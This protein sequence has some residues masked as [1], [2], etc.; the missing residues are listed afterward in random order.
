MELGYGFESTLKIKKKVTVLDLIMKIK[1][2]FGLVIDNL[3]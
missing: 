2:K 1:P 3:E